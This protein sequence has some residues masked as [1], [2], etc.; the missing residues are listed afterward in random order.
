MLYARLGSHL[1]NLAKVLEMHLGRGEEYVEIFYGDENNSHRQVGPEEFL[2]PKEIAKFKDSIL[3]LEDDMV[4]FVKLGSHLVN[5]AR[6]LDIDIKK[7]SVDIYY[8]I[9]GEHTSID[10][11]SIEPNAL[12]ELNAY[13]VAKA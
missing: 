10:R 4:C 8:D 5:L 2:K 1:F 3:D 11:E 12:E 6:V 9:A 7:D 13:A